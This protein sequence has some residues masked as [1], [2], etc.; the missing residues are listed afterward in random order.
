MQASTGCEL[1]TSTVSGHFFWR[2]VETR[3]DGAEPAHRGF[4]HAQPGLDTRSELS[5]PASTRVSAPTRLCRRRSAAARRRGS[6]YRLMRLRI[7][8]QGCSNRPSAASRFPTALQIL[9]LAPAPLFKGRRGI[10]AAGEDPVQIGSPATSLNSG[11]L[12]VGRPIRPCQSPG[13]CCATVS[14]RQAIIDAIES[15]KCGMA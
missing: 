5:R 7:V 1:R 4:R 6:C 9:S 10:R 11:R 3:R 12:M 8:V 15:A 2:S 13:K 14:T